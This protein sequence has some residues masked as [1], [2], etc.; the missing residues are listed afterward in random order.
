MNI[1]ERTPIM[2]RILAAIGT[3]VVSA[4]I[5]LFAWNSF[6]TEVFALEPLG[7]KEA[8]GLTL[9]AV[10]A[11]RALSSHRGHYGWRK[12]YGAD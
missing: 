7:F 1:R 9:L 8:L 10:L 4:S 5:V 2:S 11:G 6:V 12:R 3:L